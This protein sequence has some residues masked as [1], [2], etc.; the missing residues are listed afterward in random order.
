VGYGFLQAADLDVGE[1]F[2]MVIDGAAVELDIVGWYLDT[3]DAGKVVLVREE[4]LPVLSR[5]ATYRVVADDGIDRHAL[6]ATLGAQLDGHHVE[7][8]DFD[9]AGLSAIVGTLVAF[10]A[11]LGAVAGANLLATTLTATRE[12][13][14]ALGVLRTVGCT[15]RQLVTQAAVGA[16]TIG[17]VAVVVG[18]PV[19]L[20]VYR[21]LSDAISAGA[22]VGPGLASMPSPWFTAAVVPVAVLVSA[23]A[24]ALAAAG[25][26][27]QPA[28]ALVR[29]E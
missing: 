5:P 25:L 18:V 8:T 24:G 22:G 29:Y 26:S 27:R 11:L 19:G 6:A 1:R 12:R 10:A 14:R 13:A 17:L 21:L 7:A 20:V 9:D 28:A 16:G 23:G 2:T 3:A 4:S 15:T